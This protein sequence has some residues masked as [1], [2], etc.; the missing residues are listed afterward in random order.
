M[1]DFDALPEEIKKIINSNITLKTLVNQYKNLICTGSNGKITRL[2]K[3]IIFYAIVVELMDWK[4]ITDITDVNDSF[5]EKKL[6]EI[7]NNWFEQED[8][9]IKLEDKIKI[10]EDKIKE[11]IEKIFSGKPLVI[12]MQDNNYFPITLCDFNALPEAIKKKCEEKIKNAYLKDKNCYLDKKSIFRAIISILME[13]G[14][15][16]DITVVNNSFVEN[17]LFEIIDNWF[18][19]EGHFKIMNKNDNYSADYE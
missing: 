4:I 9:I 1:C 5:I 17:K 2:P 6:F 15:I 18:E 19:Q 8:R 16:S 11:S 10:L 14:I 13:K 7:I 3:I 12:L